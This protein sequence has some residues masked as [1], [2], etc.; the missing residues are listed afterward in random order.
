MK[1]R[2]SLINLR[3]LRV[4]QFVITKL[5]TML[6]NF[7][8]LSC[9]RIVKHIIFNFETHGRSTQRIANCRVQGSFCPL[10]QERRWLH[11]HQGIS[12]LI[13][14]AR[15][16]DAIAGPEPH[17]GRITGHDQLSRRRRQRHH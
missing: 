4:I 1:S 17:R 9:T 6:F 12:P 2:K 8:K 15:H 14:G 10:R 16:C 11:H 7:S 3:H 13:A 5:V